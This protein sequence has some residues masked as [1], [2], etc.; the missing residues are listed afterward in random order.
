MK[1]LHTSDWR[2]GQ[3]FM[4]K[5][6]ADE[7]EAFLFWLLEIIKE[8]HVEVL[9]VHVI[10]TDDEDENV[11]IPINLVPFVLLEKLRKIK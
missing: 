7:H 3:N 6:R 9:N 8:K 10:T 4:G 11:I 2:L 1:L 5:S